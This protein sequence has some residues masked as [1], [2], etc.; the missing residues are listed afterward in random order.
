MGSVIQ[1]NQDISSFLVTKISWR[2]KYKRIL[3]IGNHA[4]TTY[5]PSNYE[6]TNQW[7]Y[8]E[9]LGMKAVD[10]FEFALTL[11]RKKKKETMKFTCDFRS[12]LLFEFLRVKLNPEDQRRDCKRYEAYKHH[13]SG[14]KLPIILEVNLYGVLQ[15]EPTTKHQLAVYPFYGIEGIALVEDSSQ[16]IVL[17]TAGFNRLHMFDVP[18]RNEF[19]TKIN[20][21]ALNHAA[22]PIK[23][24]KPFNSMNQAVL[25]R[26]G[27]YSLDQH[28]TSLIEF[29]VHKMSHR[30]PDSV[31]RLLCLTETCL[32]ERDPDTY[33]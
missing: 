14:I 19:C 10:K 15:L 30:H 2:G 27:I 12:E 29:S 7:P 5:N 26:L 16:G 25:E 21:N 32:L 13:W 20:E 8:S 17:R 3:S 18:N 9:V 22:C 28:L 4:L 23:Q 33:R 31:R 1:D 11:N 24:L 6:V